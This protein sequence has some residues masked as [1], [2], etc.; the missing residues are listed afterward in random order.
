LGLSQETWRSK[1]KWEG[2]SGYSYQKNTQGIT[3][4]SGWR[5]TAYNKYTHFLIGATECWNI[6]GPG[7]RKIVSSPSALRTQQIRLPL[8]S[9]QTGFSKLCHLLFHTSSTVGVGQ[10]VGML[11]DPVTL[12]KRSQRSPLL[13]TIT[14]WPFIVLSVVS[15]PLTDATNR[16]QCDLFRDMH[17]HHRAIE[18]EFGCELSVCTL[19][20]FVQ[21]V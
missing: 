18:I 11:Y 10:L 6:Q 15:H 14:S 12:Q 3:A 20:I 13:E 7:H 2:V 1:L 8:E 16:N 5:M 21:I 4:R 17:I 9:A 19:H